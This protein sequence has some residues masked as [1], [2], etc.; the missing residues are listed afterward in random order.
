[1]KA[2]KKLLLLVF[3]M[4]FLIFDSLFSGSLK[5]VQVDLEGGIP[6]SITELTNLGKHTLKFH[7]IVSCNV[8]GAK[9]T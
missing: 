1:M 3:K 7:Q 5:M 6:E 4:H 8:I 9:L 2:K